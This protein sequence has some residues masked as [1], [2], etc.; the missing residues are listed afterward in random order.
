M[1]FQYVRTAISLA[2]PSA[3]LVAGVLL[4]DISY[5]AT[6]LPSKNHQAKCPSNY[7]RDGD[8]CMPARYAKKG[9]RKSGKC[10]SGYFADGEFCMKAKK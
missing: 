8:Y 5:A 10:P 2:S 9:V 3:M 6:V 1:R 4:A 7:Y